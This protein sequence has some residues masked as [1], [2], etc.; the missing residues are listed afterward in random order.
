MTCHLSRVL[1]GVLYSFDLVIVLKFPASEL[2][3]E[4]GNSMKS[5]RADFRLLGG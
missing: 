2:K 4:L 3:F 1:C 5:Q